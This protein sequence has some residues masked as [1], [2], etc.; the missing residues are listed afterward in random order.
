MGLATIALVLGF[1]SL[2]L[3]IYQI[4]SVFS[5]RGPFVY[6]PLPRLLFTFYG[7]SFIFALGMVAITIIVAAV[8]IGLA[9]KQPMVYA[10]RGRSLAAILMSVL[11]TIVAV[12]AF[13][14]L[15][16]N[17]WSSRTSS[18]TPSYSSTPTP[19]PTPRPSIYAKELIKPTLGSFTLIKT[20]TREDVRKVSSGDMLTAI[21]KFSTMSRRI[22]LD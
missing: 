3:M 8:A 12:A 13:S 22:S 4:F 14:I 2:F 10:G 20:M 5:R 9:F 7:L 18:Y 11:S 1:L 16:I 17:Y 6:L 19:T 15:R 21:Q